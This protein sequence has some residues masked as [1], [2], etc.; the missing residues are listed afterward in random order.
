MDLRNF[1]NGNDEVL[2]MLIT[3]IIIIMILACFC[4]SL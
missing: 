4:G 1:F 2:S 3:I